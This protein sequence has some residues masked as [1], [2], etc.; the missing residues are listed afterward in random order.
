MEV[1]NVQFDSEERK[2]IVAEFSSVQ[3]ASFWGN[4]GV[5]SRDDDRYTQFQ[6][7]TGTTTS[8][9]TTPAL[10]RAFSFLRS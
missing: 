10:K 8:A 5:V 6:L 2:V 3:D 4:L 1:I 9:S 7:K